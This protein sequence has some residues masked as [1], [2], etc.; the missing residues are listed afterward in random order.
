MIPL[1]DVAVEKLCV[2]LREMNVEAVAVCLLW[3]IVNPSTNYAS[4]KS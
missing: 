1:D 2:K 4:A 3:S